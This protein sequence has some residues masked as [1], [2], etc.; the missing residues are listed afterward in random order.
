MLTTHFQRFFV[1]IYIV[2]NTIYEQA[3]WTKFL[4]AVIYTVLAKSLG[5][6]WSKMIWYGSLSERNDG[7]GAEGEGENEG[8][9]SVMQNGRER[10]G[11]KFM[12]NGGRDLASDPPRPV[13]VTD[14]RQNR[15]WAISH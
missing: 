6:N 12:G 5:E 8:L 15:A 13:F 1:S 7:V 14:L 3:K 2:K 10:F 11:F 4:L 9:G